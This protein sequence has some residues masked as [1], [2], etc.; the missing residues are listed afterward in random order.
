M[1]Y[2]ITSNIL[3]ISEISYAILHHDNAP[4]HKSIKSYCARVLSR[5][6]NECHWP[7]TVLAWYGP[8]WLPPVPVLGRYFE[9][10]KENSL[11]EL[12]TKPQSTYE[13]CMVNLSSAAILVHWTRSGWQNKFCWINNFF[14]VYFTMPSTF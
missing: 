2:Y 3:K 11:K 8:V 6:R 9:D 5:K 10:I 14:V 13:K 12:K 7:S 1:R 4:L